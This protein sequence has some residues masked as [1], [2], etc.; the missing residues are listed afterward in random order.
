[1]NA[2]PKVS[3]DE[4]R[5][6]G[7]Q[8]E[9]EGFEPGVIGHPLRLLRRQLLN[10]VEQMVDSTPGLK[11]AKVEVLLTTK[12]GKRKPRFEIRISGLYRAGDVRAMRGNLKRLNRA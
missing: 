1:M 7:L 3:P 4:V 2:R 10:R 9:L 12:P 5:R 11:D 6:R 8:A